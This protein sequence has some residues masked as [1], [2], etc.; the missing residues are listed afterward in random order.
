MVQALGDRVAEAMAEMMHKKMR[1]LWG[2]GKEENLSPEDLIKEKYRGIRPA[3]GYPAC[4]DHTEK[5]TLWRLLDAEKNIGVKLTENFAIY[6]PS[7]VAGLYFGHPDSKYIHVGQI[8]RDQ[9]EDY[10][11]RKGISEEEAEK[12]LRPNLG[13]DSSSEKK[14][15]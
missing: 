5:E 14:A 8:N 12:W 4:P 2:Y 7:S 3:P 1:D 11:A 9:V 6:P 13:Y 15:V 10:A